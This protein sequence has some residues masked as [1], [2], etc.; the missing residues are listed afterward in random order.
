M[1]KGEAKAQASCYVKV[2][3]LGFFLHGLL[4]IKVAEFSLLI[5]S[6]L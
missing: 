1:K 2:F 5:L 4:L 6:L 3:I